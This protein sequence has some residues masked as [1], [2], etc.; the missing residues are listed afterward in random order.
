MLTIDETG[1]DPLC[2]LLDI[3]GNAVEIYENKQPDVQKFLA[4]HANMPK[5][6]ALLKLLM[7][8][9]GLGV[10]NFKNEIGSKS[11]VS[12][13]LSRDRQL[14]KKHIGKLCVRFNL[15]PELFF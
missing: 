7:G 10:N 2:D 4:K 12:M 15:S 5:D 11:Y 1:N 6:I 8:Q 3:I 9:Y 13:I 14:S